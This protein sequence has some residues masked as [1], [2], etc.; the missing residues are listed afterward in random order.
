[1]ILEKSRS[2]DVDE[3]KGQRTMM[4]N[5]LQKIESLKNIALFSTLTSSELGAI[6]SMIVMRNYKKNETILHEENT[7]EYMYII[8]DGETKVMQTTSEG[9]E[10]MVT[11]HQTGDFFGEL[12][13]IDG[14]TAPAAVLATRDSTTALISKKDFYSILY[15]Q[16]KVLKNLLVIMCARLRESQA[17]IK[18]LNFNN[19]SQRI[20]MLFLMLSETF[21]EK[22]DEGTELK[23]RLIH[24]DIADMTGLSRETVTRILD[25]LRKNG[26]IH[27]LKNRHIL[28][29]PEFESLQI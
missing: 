19:A 1:M 13:L 27:I 12:S 6:R 20:K 14:K 11:M 29:K 24:Q 26:E 7:N 22:N 23:I 3:P 18:M 2:R 5:E 15:S 28:L 9:K 8:V 25:K 4:M 16:N 17:K 10:I 21:G